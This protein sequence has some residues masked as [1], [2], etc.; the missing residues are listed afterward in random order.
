MKRALAILALLLTLVTCATAQNETHKRAEIERTLHAFLE[1]FDNLEWDKFRG[2]FADDATVFYPRGV[3]QRAE[4]REE[5]E[6]AFRDVFAQIRGDRTA[7]PYMH[8]E[9]RDLRIQ[10]AG[11]VA[12]VTFL[13]DDRPP[14]VNRRTVVLERRGG[15]WKIIHLHA[16]EVFP[17]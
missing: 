17:K 3:A 5:Y 6:R 12:I 9:P 15:A 8:L 10:F 2:F 7:P 11:D 13:L 16:S 14:S 1:A 4:G